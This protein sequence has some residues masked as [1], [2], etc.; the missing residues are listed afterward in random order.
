MSASILAT[1]ASPT[2]QQRSRKRRR[3]CA[4]L[5]QTRAPGLASLGLR[6]AISR[7]PSLLVLG[8]AGQALSDEQ[9]VSKNV[10]ICR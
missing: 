2:G 5:R 1:R 9:A 3:L 10:L 7:I 8:A 4:H 6:V